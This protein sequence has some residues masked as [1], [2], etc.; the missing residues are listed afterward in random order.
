MGNN[1]T[2]Y[3]DFDMTLCNMD[4][5]PTDRH[6]GLS[7]PYPKPG[8]W[9][10]RPR[11]VRYYSKRYLIYRQAWLDREAAKRVYVAW[12]TLEDEMTK[13]VGVPRK[14]TNNEPGQD[15]FGPVVLV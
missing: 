7:V 9:L 2:L 13:L 10:D 12:H 15:F 6:A 4:N 11:A 14:G 1:R 8:V 3:I 5:V